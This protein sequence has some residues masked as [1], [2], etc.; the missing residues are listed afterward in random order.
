MT[1]EEIKA[2]KQYWRDT[3]VSGVYFLF[4]REEL[5]YIG[6]STHC[7]ERIREHRKDKDL[8]AIEFDIIKEFKPPLNKDYTMVTH[9]NWRE[10]SKHKK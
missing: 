6:S 8:Y 5:V 1:L 9:E 3:R 2:N 10:I 7:H 4:D